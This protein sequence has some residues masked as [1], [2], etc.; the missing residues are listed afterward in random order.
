MPTLI[1]SIRASGRT[2]RP[3]RSDSTRTRSSASPSSMKGPFVGSAARTMF[4][5]T[6]ITGMSMKCWCT[7]PIP[8]SIASRGELMRSGLP[9]SRNSP[10]SGW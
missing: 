4:S 6:V 7:M 2:A 3:N 9:F 5:A 8:A 1:D 10:S